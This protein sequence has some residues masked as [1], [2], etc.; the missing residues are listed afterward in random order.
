[1]RNTD[2]E[3]IVNPVGRGGGARDAGT[4]PPAACLMMP[5]DRPSASKTSVSRTATAKPCSTARQT[6]QPLIAPWPSQCP[7]GQESPASAATRPARLGT[8]AAT[9]ATMPGWAAC[10]A[11]PTLVC[12]TVCMTAS[13]SSVQASS[14]HRTNGR[15]GSGWAV[16]TTP[17]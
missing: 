14:S 6:L 17:R 1:M 16:I 4:V 5:R 12:P 13:P 8:C 10:A 7:P 9:S 2:I 15:G 3:A 11:M